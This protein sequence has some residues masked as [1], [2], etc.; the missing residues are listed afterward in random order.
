MYV[1]YVWSVITC[2]IFYLHVHEICDGFFFFSECGKTANLLASPFGK[3]CL[4]YVHR[5]T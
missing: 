4:P 2:I 3:D 5:Q 1:Q